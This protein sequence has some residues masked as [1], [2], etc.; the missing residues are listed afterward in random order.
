MFVHFMSSQI[1]TRDNKMEI[2]LYQPRLYSVW[3][4]VYNVQCAHI[5]TLDLSSLFIEI[6]CKIH[7]CNSSSHFAQ[8]VQNFPNISLM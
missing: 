2:Y 4:T 7:G 1:N 6:Q 5:E 8:Q 3:C